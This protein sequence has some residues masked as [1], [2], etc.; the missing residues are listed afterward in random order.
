MTFDELLRAEH[1]HPVVALFYGTN[2]APCNALKPKLR[3]VCKQTGTPLEEF[4]SAAELPM[5]RMLGLRSVPAVVTVHR[6]EWF[7][8]FTGDKPAGEIAGLLEQAGLR[9]A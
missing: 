7:I 8:A 3:E 9:A 4:N 5:V 2:C 6:G 1:A